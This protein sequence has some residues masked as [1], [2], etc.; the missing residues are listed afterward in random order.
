[1]LDPASWDG[2]GGLD[3]IVDRVAHV[4]LKDVSRAGE[5]VRIGDGIVDFRAQLACLA[6]AGYDGYLSFE[7]HYA[8]DGS[9]ELATRDCVAALKTFA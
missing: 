7:T 3:S 9:G 1:M 4:H 6:D 8:R 5:W 2:L